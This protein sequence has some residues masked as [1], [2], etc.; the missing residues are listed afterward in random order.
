MT[1]WWWITLVKQFGGEIWTEEG[2][3]CPDHG[4]K[5]AT[6]YYA[7]LVT[8]G[9][10]PANIGDD[11]YSGFLSGEY[12][13]HISGGW[14]MSP[15]MEKSRNATLGFE[16]AVTA[17]PQLGADNGILAAHA[18]ASGFMI[19]NSE[20]NPISAEKKQIGLE[21]IGWMTKNNIYCCLLYTS[22][23]PRDRG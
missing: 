3:W 8:E 17:V 20:A 19:P 7:S 14:S 12:P 15:V 16:Y 9:Y 2:G 18:H 5:Q 23:S 4:C 21:I 6:E 10:S 13:I 11:S 22:P 1:Y